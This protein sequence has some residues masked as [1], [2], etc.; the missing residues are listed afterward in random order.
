MKRDAKILGVKKDLSVQERSG[1]I[2]RNQLSKQRDNVF[3]RLT[4]IDR[5]ETIETRRQTMWGEHGLQ[6]VL[7]EWGL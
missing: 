6:S 2:K 1:E 5:K 4:D 3:L 7:W